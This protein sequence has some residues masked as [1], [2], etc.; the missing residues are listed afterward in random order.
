MTP[1]EVLVQRILQKLSEGVV[2]W[3]KMWNAN[4]RAVS[5]LTQ[6]PYRGFNAMVLDSGEYATLNQINKLGGKVKKGEKGTPIAFFKWVKNE[7]ED[8]N[9][10]MLRYYVVFET[11]T[12]VDGLPS[13]R[14]IKE[15][16]NSNPIE[17]AEKIVKE[18]ETMPPIKHG[19]PAYRPSTDELSM[20]DLKEFD[21][22]SEYYSALFH[23]AVHSTGHKSRLNRAGITESNGFGSETYSKE[24]LVAEIGSAMLCGESNIEGTFDN[25]VAYIGSW[26]KRLQND[27]KMIINAS[28]QAQKAVDFITNKKFQTEE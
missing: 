24:E 1:Q 26:L 12:Q 18:Y 19:D 8:K 10:S 28:Q 6:K 15:N 22:A 3:Q 7:E 16:V 13:K 2:P 27:P 23:E 5:Y 11:N 4:T 17:S 9:F 20:P 14:K 25:S 21:S